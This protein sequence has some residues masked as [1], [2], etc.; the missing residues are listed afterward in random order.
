MILKNLIRSLTVRFKNDYCSV[1]VANYRLIT[2]IRFVVKNYDHPWKGFAN[3]LHLVFYVR[4]ILFLG[5][6]CGSCGMQTKQGRKTREES[7][8]THAWAPACMNERALALTNKKKGDHMAGTSP[9]HACMHARIYWQ[10]RGDATCFPALL[11]FRSHRMAAASIYQLASSCLRRRP[12]R[13]WIGGSSSPLLN[14][15]LPCTCTRQMRL[16]AAAKRGL[17]VSRPS[18]PPPSYSPV[19]SHI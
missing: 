17:A 19:A 15:A 12:V 11:F 13:S 9:M 4:E 2:V 8:S 6:V 16:D 10:F 3:K 14:N 7:T 18:L 1:I 5:I